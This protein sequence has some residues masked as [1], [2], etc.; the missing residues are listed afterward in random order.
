MERGGVGTGKRL[1]GEVDAAQRWSLSR[2]RRV[3]RKGESGSGGP[4]LGVRV[5][6]TSRV[7]S[8][9]GGGNGRLASGVRAQTG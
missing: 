8:R 9:G 3:P 7:R 1:G 4:A 6:E 2:V 5:S